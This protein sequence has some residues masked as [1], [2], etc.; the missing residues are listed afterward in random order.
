MLS[1]ILP[2]VDSSS[3]N[4]NKETFKFDSAIIITLPL[5]TQPII[6][7]SQDHHTFAI[8]QERTVNLI[9]RTSREVD[10]TLIFGN[11]HSSFNLLNPNRAYNRSSHIY[12]KR[13]ILMCIWQLF[14]SLLCSY[15]KQ[16]CHIFRCDKIRWEW[17]L[18]AFINVDGLHGWLW[19]YSWKTLFTIEQQHSTHF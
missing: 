5:R 4:S 11:F 1:S 16:K 10:A 17:H 15:W 18:F 12:K 7:Y 14:I 8:G 19:A 9:R 3:L 2:P 13:V 6:S